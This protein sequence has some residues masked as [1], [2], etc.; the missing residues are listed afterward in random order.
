M[1]RHDAFIQK[2]WEKG[3]LA[4]IAVW[5]TRGDGSVDY[6][7]FLVD[8]YCLGVKECI[9]E[10]SVTA[11]DVAADIDLQLPEAVRERIHPACAKKLIEGA[12]AYAQS[13]GF[14]PHRDFR[15]AR[16]VLNGIDAADCPREFTYGL[17]GKPCYVRGPDDDDERVDRILAILEARCGEDGYDYM[18]PEVEDDDEL[19]ELA[20]REELMDFL[21][22]EPESVPRFYEV[23]GLITAMSICPT[24]LTPLKLLDVLWGP[25]GKQWKSHEEMQEFTNL[26]MDYWNL[27]NDLIADAL[28]PDAHPDEVIIDLQAGDF[29]DL[30]E[31]EGQVMANASMTLASAEWM[32]GFLRATTL[33]P[34]AWGNALTRTDLAAHWEVVRWWADFSREENLVRLQDATGISPPGRMDIAAL[35]LA[36]ALRPREPDLF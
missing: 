27:V 35:A 23:S 5:R 13:L 18:D 3:G 32:R 9:A 20:L 4:S 16:K 14:A 24:V 7:I 8:A 33:W 30:V 29:A 10:S 25:Q 15:K 2:D 21:N 22:A 26:L 1:I 28:A 12:V 6:A 34:K 11:S 17:D 31:A 36:R 19:D